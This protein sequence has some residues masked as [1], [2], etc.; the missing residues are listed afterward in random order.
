VNCVTPDGKLEHVQPIGADPKK[1][2]PTHSDVFGVGAFLLAGSEVYRLTL[3]RAPAPAYCA[4]MPQRMDDF[5]WENDRIAFRAYGP[6]LE[7]AGEISSGI[8]VWVKRT[9]RPVIE[10]WYYN[11]NYHEDL[12]EGLDM[13]KVGPSRGCGGSGIWRSNNLYVAKN[14]LTWHIVQ[15]GPSRITFELTYAPYNAGG[16][17]IRERKRISLDSGSNLNR[18]ESLMDWDWSGPERL[19]LAVGIVKQ[20][21]SESVDFANDD[22]W[23]SCWEPA[24]AENGAIGCGVVMSSP[25][26]R[27]DTADQAFL[28]TSIGRGQPLVYY[29]GAGWTRSGDFPNRESWVRYVSRSAEKIK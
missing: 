12:G 26:R 16:V 4:F 29:A 19:T 14:F 18:I 11:A 25:S 13:Y 3:A 21:G 8:D 20:P 7:R 6:A 5:A 2:D 23:M 28:Q 10:K 27:R 24:Q 17:T 1:F 9:R 15:C 22:S